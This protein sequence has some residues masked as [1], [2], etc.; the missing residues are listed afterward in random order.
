M[1]MSKHATVGKTYLSRIANQEQRA[2]DVADLL[3]VQHAPEYRTE[4]KA[5]ARST[6]ES[7]QQALRMRPARGR[8]RIESVD[9]DYPGPFRLTLDIGP[10]LE[11]NRMV[12][13]RDWW[14]TER[15]LQF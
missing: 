15:P 12:V 2:R 10:D 1:V 11:R 6:V 9:W 4:F 8:R 7:Y 5:S 14:L 3:G 13:E